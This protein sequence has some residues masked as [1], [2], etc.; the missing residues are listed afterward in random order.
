MNEKLPIIL[1]A[2]DDK[3]VR[4]VV[5]QALTRQGFAVQSIGTAAGLWKLSGS[6]RGAGLRTAV[7]VAVGE[8]GGRVPRF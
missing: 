3:S 1:V 7:A 6:G 2:E 4:L 5:Q 8:A